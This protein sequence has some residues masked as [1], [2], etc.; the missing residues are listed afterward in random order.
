MSTTY[1]QTNS[2]SL[3]ESY[4]S[5]DQL[6][7]MLTNEENDIPVPYSDSQGN[8]TIGI[9]VNLTVTTNMA[10]V[11]QQL[12]VLTSSQTVSQ[13]RQLVAQF[14]QVITQNLPISE[15][16]PPGTSASEQ[17]LQLALNAELQKIPGI[18][19]T[20]F[21]LNL[22]QATSVLDSIVQGYSITATDGTR[23]T[24]NGKQTR[25]NDILKTNGSIIPPDTEEYK[26]L[27]SLFYNSL[28]ETGPDALI[29]P[30]L[31]SALAAGNRAEAWYEIR[32]DTNKDSLNASAPSDAPGIAKRRY[33]ESQ[34]FGLFSNP[35]T[36]SWSD[37][38]QAYQMLT[39]HRDRILAYDTLY[40]AEIPKANSAYGLSNTS[41]AVQTLV[42]SLQPAET[43]LVQAL[44]KQYGNIL[45]N[46][47]LTNA[48]DLYLNPGRS[49]SSQTVSSAYAATLDASFS[50]DN[51]LLVASTGG[52]TGLLTPDTG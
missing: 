45:A 29:G 18:S 25:L 2:Q 10:L 35:V 1:W 3:G 23:F 15:G 43:V 34:T 5:P 27:M 13:Q 6:P 12:G 11:L 30:R 8:P 44:Q 40:G 48:T 42:A 31:L 51:N 9:G 21:S 16:F 39:A 46:L 50:P 49:L 4:L 7:L 28:H 19:T 36:P 41:S 20:K 24:D 47:N 38:V 26:A 22:T 32:Y 33:Y 37:T 52:P 14:E 17:K